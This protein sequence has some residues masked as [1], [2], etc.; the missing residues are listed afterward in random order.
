MRVLAM[1]LM[2]L[3][4]PS[5]ALAQD[6]AQSLADIRQDLNVLYVEIQ[7]L[8]Q[9]LSTTGSP[10]GTGAAGSV[11]DRSVRWKHNCSA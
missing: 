6:R 8:K 10:S 2:T 3:I 4:G 5:M 7:R 9:E 1:V 11:L